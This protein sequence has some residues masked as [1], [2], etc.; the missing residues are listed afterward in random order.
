MSKLI[1]L[2]EIAR[3]SVPQGVLVEDWIELYN[4]K[5]ADLIL[6]ECYRICEQGSA[7]QTTSVGII[8]KLKQHF[9]ND[10]EYELT[11]HEKQAEFDKDRNYF[12]DRFFAGPDND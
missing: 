3:K 10:A 11:T 12:Y 2:S 8:P 1:E 6:Q 7:T 9:Q 4:A 5:Y